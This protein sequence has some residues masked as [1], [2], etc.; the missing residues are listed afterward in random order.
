MFTTEMDLNLDLLLRFF[1]KYTAGQQYNR[2]EVVLIESGQTFQIGVCNVLPGTLTQSFFV[3]SE[4]VVFSADD[5]ASSGNASYVRATPTSISVGGVPVGEIFDNTIQNALDKILYPFIGSNLSLTLNTL[6]EKGTSQNIE[7]TAIITANQD[8]ISNI[9]IMQGLTTLF[10]S[11]TNS[12]TYT[13]IGVSS[14][15]TY[16]LQVAVQGG[17]A[18]IQNAT[19]N[20]VAPTYFGVEAIGANGATIKTLTKNI[21]NKNTR[22]FTFSPT[23][24]RMYYAYPASFGGL[25]EIKDQNGLIITDGWELQVMDITLANSSVESYNVYYNNS[26]TTLTNYE[27]TFKF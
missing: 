12:F 9:S 11:G 5:I 14:D 18:K 19:V 17:G 8:I 13:D 22:T 24:Q 2:E 1:N 23:I 26:N 20:F 27:I 16:T 21:F 7:L 25:S 10:T 3:P 15:K 4:W 6:R